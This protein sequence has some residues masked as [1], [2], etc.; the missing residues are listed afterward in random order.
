VTFDPS[1]LRESIEQVFGDKN[2][3]DAPSVKVRDYEAF[4]RVAAKMFYTSKPEG[5]QVETAYHTLKNSELSPSE[6]ER[7]WK[8][9]KP[10]ANRLLNED[11][12]P[13]DLKMLEGGH[14]GDI[15]SYYMNHP[16]PQYPEASAGDIARYGAVSLHPARRLAGRPPN[17]VELHKFVMG[18]YS[19]DD[20]VQHY[21]EGSQTVK[22]NAQS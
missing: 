7:L 18:N 14:P 20:I 13:Q 19:M 15:Q 4:A 11:P 2:H 8:V 12:T 17:L 21:S 9:A 6:F 22:D 16:H 5:K 1:R 10:L 3:P